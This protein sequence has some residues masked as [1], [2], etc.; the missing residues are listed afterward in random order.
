MTLLASSGRVGTGQG[1]VTVVMIKIHMIP[2]ARVM[3]G[4][5]ILAVL[6]ILIVAQLGG[7]GKKTELPHGNSV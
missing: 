5:T 7:W 2:T 3:T 4:R 6:T 1:E